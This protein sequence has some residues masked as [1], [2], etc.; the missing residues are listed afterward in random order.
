[1]H[2]SAEFDSQGDVDDFFQVPSTDP[3]ALPPPNADHAEVLTAA[4]VYKLLKNLG[5]KWVDVDTMEFQLP[6]PSM[7]PG[8]TP[9][10]VG[11]I[12]H[13]GWFPLQQLAFEGPTTRTTTMRLD[14]SLLM[15]Q[16]MHIGVCFDN[17]PRYPQRDVWA[18][19]EAAAR[20]V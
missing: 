7:A 18:A 11:T 4:G 10:P 2:L 13:L 9:S 19:I 14:V 20:M 8:I 5:A 12:G 15:L 16:L 3:M 6:R 1:M 17:G